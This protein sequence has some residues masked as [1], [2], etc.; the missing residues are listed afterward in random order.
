MWIFKKLGKVFFLFFC[1]FL[2]PHPWHMEVPR[3]GVKSEL[4]LL[5]YA[6]ATATW[7]PSHIFDQHHSSQKCQILNRLSKA[8][9][10]THNLMV[11]CWIRFCCATMGTP[12]FYL[13]K[14]NL[15]FK[16]FSG[17]PIVA[18]QVTNAASI[19]EDADSF[20]G[21]TLWVKDLALLWL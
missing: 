17:V 2:G 5:A 18:Q 21:L 12:K 10:R 15:E 11:P 20:P 14:K 3:L 1:L 8:R 16:K 9:D 6:T 4:L 7:D 13:F 19:H